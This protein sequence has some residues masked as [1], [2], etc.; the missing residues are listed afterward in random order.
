MRTPTLLALASLASITA[1]AAAQP[2][3][4]ITSINDDLAGN[5]NSVTGWAY[6][7]AIPGYA[8]MK[9]TRGVG[10]Q[11]L[12]GVAPG[13]G[14]PIFCS[15]DGSVLAASMDNNAN[16][17]GLN[18]F[19]GYDSAG[20]L[21]VLQ[22]PCSMPSITHRYTA[23]TGWVNAGSL[24][25]TVDGATGRM[26]GG[27]RCDFTINSPADISNDGRFI[28][29]GAWSAVTV[30]GSGGVS[31]GFCGDFYGFRYDSLT[32]Q[33]DRLFG[34]STT[35]RAD[36][37]NADGTVITG[38]DLGTIPDPAGAYTGR[39]MAVWLNGS[40][41]IL[42]TFGNQSGAPVNGPGTVV[43]AGASRN[44][45]V[46][47]FGINKMTLVKWTRSGNAWVPQNL[48]RPIDREDEWGTIYPFNAIAASGISDDGNTIVG[49]A[50]YGGS[51]GQF[52]GEPRPFICRPDINEGTPL[53]LYDYLATIDPSGTA[54]QG[55]RIT[56]VRG[57]SADGN[58]LLVSGQDSRT[59]CTPPNQSLVT[60]ISGLLSLNGAAVGN[61]PPTIAV[62]PVDRS[63]R[64]EWAGWGE[65]VNITAGGTWPLN[66]QWQRED[67]SAPGTWINLT[68][69]CSGLPEMTFPHDASWEFEGVHGAQLRVNVVGQGGGHEGRYRCIVSNAY[70][71]VTS[72]PATLTFEGPIN[73]L[74]PQPATGCANAPATF[75]VGQIPG[76][77]EYRWEI[78]TDPSQGTWA[79]LTDGTNALS[80]G[81]ITVSGTRTHTLTVNPG[82]LSPTQTYD[83]RCHIADS[84]NTLDSDPGTLTIGSPCGPADIGGQ[85]GQAV[86]CG[87]GL[88]NNNDFVVFIDYFFTVNPRADMGS[89]GGAPGADGQFDNNDFVVF[90]DYF[91]SGC[92]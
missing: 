65:V 59:D 36:R 69:A 56:A 29:G 77:V 47:N 87:D 38:Y 32:G 43:A 71:S 18:C 33:F 75:T 58:T 3:L 50:Y 4:V 60:F 86:S 30:N 57:L 52:T 91:F 51:A 17:G 81:T 66:Y 68:N 73:P 34:S 89:Q 78:C 76:G 48:G 49:T 45:S 64:C 28:V 23:G 11:R 2:K 20:N 13:S 24:P 53:D 9:W 62:Q 39:R 6:D 40:M 41:T 55:T 74:T 67:P 46:A 80:M 54:L 35:N 8:A 72:E 7:G 26:I 84:C 12:P 61:E 85:G 83:F 79:I 25:R 90:I 22:N 31:Q 37:V 16:W 63:T 27:T 70:G 14:G 92:N 82:T 5:G 42:D 19:P 1:I 88:L 44:Y 10:F 21:K 15:G